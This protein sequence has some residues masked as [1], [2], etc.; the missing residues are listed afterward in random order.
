[1][2]RLRFLLAVAVFTATVASTVPAAPT[3]EADPNQ[4]YPIQPTTGGWLVCVASYSGPE[5]K[6]L[7]RQ[8]VHWIRT[9]HNAPA[10][11]FNRAD[12][13]R[14]QLNEEFA[15]NGLRK[16]VRVEEQYAVLVGGYADDATAAKARDVIRRWPVPD[17]KLANGDSALDQFLEAGTKQMKPVNPFTNALV[18][19]NPVAPKPTNAAPKVD[20]FLKRLNEGEE[21]SLLKNPKGWTL[22]VKQYTGGAVVGEQGKGATVLE[23]LFGSSK[24][25]GLCAGGEQAHELARVLRKLGFPAWVLH[26]RYSSVVTVGGFDSGTDAEMD[27]TRD[28]LKQLTQQVVANNPERKDPLGLFPVALPMEVPH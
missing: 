24:G 26:T 14:K 27:R 3:V 21:Y 8:L 9:K 12:E 11:V 15:R 13:T 16:T 17:L 18:I 25:E 19:R 7:A 4:L 23:K 1:M 20:A 2:R 28:R 5:A 10:Y 6:D 22:A